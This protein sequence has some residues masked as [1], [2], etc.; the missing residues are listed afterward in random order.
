MWAGILVT[1]LTVPALTVAASGGTSWFPSH[2]DAVGILIFC[3]ISF[4]VGKVANTRNKIEEV[5]RTANSELESK[6]QERTAALK[7][8]N[9]AIQHRFAE[10]EFLYAQLPVGLCFLNKSVLSSDQP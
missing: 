5:L 6:V 10:L 8:A 7:N 3:F 1:C 4:L 9:T 2:I